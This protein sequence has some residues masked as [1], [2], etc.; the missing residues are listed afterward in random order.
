MTETYIASEGVRLWSVSEGQG[1]PVVLCH[2]GPGCC[3]YLGPVADLLAGRV[4]VIRYEQ[5]GCGRSEA[6]P[7]YTIESALGDLDQVRRHYGF[8]RW[9]VAGHSWGADLALL[10]AL[11]YPAHTSGIICLA[12]G[13][14]HTDREWHATYHARRD[15]G[16]E[17]ELA[18]DYPPNLEV[19]AALNQAMHAYARRPTLYRELAGVAAPAL[20]VYGDQDIRP[21]WPVEQMANL[22]PNAHFVTLTGANHYLWHTHAAQLQALLTDFVATNAPT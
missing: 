14:I 19:N 18:W 4:Q 5:R 21:A 7:P 17:P 15:A 12:G 20:F 16:A 8:D 6:V 2:G 22:L 10:Y 1:A 11:H 9:I 3:D 13:R